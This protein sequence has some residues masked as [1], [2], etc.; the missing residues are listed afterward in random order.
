[1]MQAIPMLRHVDPQ[2]IALESVARDCYRRGAEVHW[3]VRP[4]ETCYLRFKLER[5]DSVMVCCVSLRT[6]LQEHWPD[7]EGLAWE[8]C[9]EHSLRRLVT[10]SAPPI[11]FDCASLGYERACFLGRLDAQDDSEMQPC[12]S[13]HE[14]DVWIEQ[15]HGAPSVSSASVSWLSSLVLPID[16]RIGATQLPARR[17]AGL[18]VHDIV[19]FELV[20]GRA[21]FCEQALFHFNFSTEHIVVDDILSNIESQQVGVVEETYEG[22]NVSTLSVSIDVVLCRM[23]QTL[24][25]L[26]DLQ[27][28]TTLPLPETAHR[29]VRLMVGRQ[30]VATG[31]VVQIGDRLGVQ[32][33]TVMPKT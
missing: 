7:I 9:D 13:S 25:E 28:G 10:A 14:G 15:L 30:C 12:L 1:M 6:W 16:Y 26:S 24:G 18:R 4:G 22:V 2:R 5:A 31:E 19:L 29:S 3:K 27:P 33:E 17:L 11:R 21:F 20:Y 8:R 23:Q 32:I